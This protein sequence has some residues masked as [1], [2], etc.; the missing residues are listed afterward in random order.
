MQVSEAAKLW[1]EYHKSHS[2]EN[3]IRAYKLVLSKFC[4]ECGAENLEDITTERVLSFL[5][6]ITDGRKRQTR[7]TRYSHLLAFFN[8]IKN[9]LDQDFRNPCDT[10][11]LKKLFRARPSYHWDIIEKE[12]VDEVIFRTSKPRNRLILELMARGGMRISE[13]LK[14]TPSDVNDRRLTLKEPKS[15]REQEFIFIPQRLADRLK[16]YIR[17]KGIQSN[18]RIFPICYEAAREMVAKTGS[19]V[20]IHLRP[21]DLR[22]HAATYASRSGV[23]IEIVSKVILRHSNLS[24]TERYLGKI[25]DVEAMKWIDNLYA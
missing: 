23:P 22:R 18:K 5:N 1:L 2:K 12:T 7:R 20:G 19:V 16:D 15:G 4:E 10:P 17:E 6:R 11:M 14:L 21:H 24:T 25:S 3:S 13:V 8:F 9:N